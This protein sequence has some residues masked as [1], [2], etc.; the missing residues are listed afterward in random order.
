MERNQ[1]PFFR[2]QF[3]HEQM[4]AIFLHPGL[5][6]TR[7]RGL[8]SR[9]WINPCRR[10]PSPPASCFNLWAWPGLHTNW[11]AVLSFHLYSWLVPALVFSP[12]HLQGAPNSGKSALAATLASRSGFP[13]VK[14]TLSSRSPSECPTDLDGIRCAV[15]R[16][17][18]ASPSLQSA[19]WSERSSMMLTGSISNLNTEILIF[20]NQIRAS[21]F[22]SG[23]YWA[24]IG[25]W[26]YWTALFQHH[27]SGTPCALQKGMI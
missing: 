1:F 18:S 12:E 21:L 19:P 8:E 10:R 27:P 7:D 3:P 22:V 6:V 11:G 15:Q 23:Q 25:L 17:W 5:P 26:S 2:V 13:F 9:D 24:I 4:Q 16:T 20:K 14:V